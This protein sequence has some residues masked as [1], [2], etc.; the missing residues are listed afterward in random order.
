[1]LRGSMCARSDPLPSASASFLKVLDPNLPIPLDPS[2]VTSQGPSGVG[3]D[4]EAT[5]Q[6]TRRGLRPEARRD[7]GAPRSPLSVR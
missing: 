3:R 1:M 4:P 2:S 5:P 6:P 7:G